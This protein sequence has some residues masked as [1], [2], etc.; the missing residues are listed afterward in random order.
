MFYFNKFTKIILN[1]ESEF[2]CHPDDNRLAIKYGN[3]SN[4]SQQDFFKDWINYQIDKLRK[5]SRK[6]ALL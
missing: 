3:Q 6:Y 1:F 4:L 5:I 2:V